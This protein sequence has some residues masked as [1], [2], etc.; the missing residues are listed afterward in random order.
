[1]TTFTKTIQYVFSLDPYYKLFALS[2]TKLIAESSLK[3]LIKDLTSLQLAS[4]AFPAGWNVLY[5]ES[6]LASAKALLVM[7]TLPEVSNRIIKYLEE[8]ISSYGFW[9]ENP[10]QLSAVEDFINPRDY[11]TSSL[12]SSLLAAYALKLAGC[13]TYEN[14]IEALKAAQTSNG[15]WYSQGQPSVLISSLAI[16]LFKDSLSK[17]ALLAA[18]GLKSLLSTLD[19]SPL[20]A[21]AYL[22]LGLFNPD[23]ARKGLEILRNKQLPNGGWGVKQKISSPALTSL[24]LFILSKYS[25]LNT[26]KHLTSSLNTYYSKLLELKKIII[27]NYPIIESKL[28]NLLIHNYIL[29]PKSRKETLMRIFVLSTFSNFRGDVDIFNVFSNLMKRLDFKPLIEHTDSVLSEAIFDVLFSYDIYRSLV[30]KNTKSII[31]FKNFIKEFKEFEC[32]PL[33][34]F[35]YKLAEYILFK[36]SSQIQEKLSNLG[37]LLYMYNRKIFNQSTLLLCLETLPGLSRY[38]ADFFLFLSCNIT[39]IIRSH[40][41]FL[42]VDWS[43]VKPLIMCDVFSSKLISAYKVKG[44][45]YDRVINLLSSILYNNIHKAYYLSYVSEQWCFK[46]TC[47]SIKGPCPLASI[48][49]QKYRS[50]SP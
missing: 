9:K 3:S 17:S 39:G 27:N 30:L 21:L 13:E 33:T 26:C 6:P 42:P 43:I 47:V 11:T 37:R 25:V 16:I 15:L 49:V 48:C 10:T 20:T 34:S 23:Y 44:R 46:R 4:G 24:I 32:I 28:K 12:Y 41:S 35:T 50:Y 8:S 40:Y 19:P 1:V 36:C 18:K 7:R 38:S 5:S 2:H 14:F 22:G 29:F 31:L 45:V